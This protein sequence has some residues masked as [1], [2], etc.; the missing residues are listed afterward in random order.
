M[1]QHLYYVEGEVAGSDV[2]RLHQQKKENMKI[3]VDVGANIGL[4]AIAACKRF[5]QARILSFEPHPGNYRLLNYNIRAAGCDRN[6]ETYN[7]GISKDA[8]RMRLFWHDSIGTSAYRGPT[9]WNPDPPTL[10]ME[11][12]TPEALW[13]LVGEQTVISFMKVDCEGCEYEVVPKI[14]FWRVEKMYC[15]V[16]LE[17]VNVLTGRTEIKGMTKKLMDDVK[18]ACDKGKPYNP[19]KT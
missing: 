17:T 3:I 12:I 5:P 15:E 18:R 16:H 8:R 6:V 14:P 11:S 1:A 13:K 2:Y 10:H 7:K 19:D 4:F 9:F